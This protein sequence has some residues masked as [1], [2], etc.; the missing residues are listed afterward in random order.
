M[1]L[2]KIIKEI[3]SEA[4]FCKP[5]SAGVYLVCVRKRDEFL[6]YVGREKILYVGSSQNI[7]KRLNNRN[8]PYLKAYQRFDDISV[9]T[10]SYLTDNYKE[11]EL[12]LIKKLRPILNKQGKK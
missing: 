3:F 1:D 2:D 10:R 7:A 6:N 9:Y 11:L 12:L 4:D 8:H 5:N